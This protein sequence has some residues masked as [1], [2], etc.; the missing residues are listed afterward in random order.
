M[1]PWIL[2][3]NTS[4][5]TL[6]AQKAPLLFRTTAVQDF[7]PANHWVQAWSDTALAMATMRA[8]CVNLPS[9][10]FVGLILNI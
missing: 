8:W 7:E 10:I 9:T 6:L 2:I 1:K 5:K 3:L 4:I